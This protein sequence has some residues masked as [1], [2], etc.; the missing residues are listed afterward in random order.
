MYIIKAFVK[1]FSFTERLLKHGN[2]L[3]ILCSMGVVEAQLRQVIHSVPSAQFAVN[4]SFVNDEK[5][6]A[7]SLVKSAG[8]FCGKMVYFK[9]SLCC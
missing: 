6:F 9:K 8:H 7:E 1:F 4:V 3:E 5:L 2:T